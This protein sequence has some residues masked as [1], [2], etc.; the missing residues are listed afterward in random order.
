MAGK[1][2]IYFTLITFIIG[3]M[4]AVQFNTVQKPS[5]RDA[6]DAWELRESINN[7]MELQTKL[8]HE[9]RLQDKKVHDYSSELQ[10]NKEDVLKQTILELKKEAGLTKI[11]GPGIILTVKAIDEGMLLGQPPPQTSPIVLQRLIN[12]LNM[13]GAKSIAIDGERYINTTV[14]RDINGETKVG[15]HAINYLPFQIHVLTE[16]MEIAEKLYNHMQISPVLDDFFI[17]NLQ[18]DVS[19]PKKSIEL[20]A[21]VYPITTRDME[22]VEEKGDV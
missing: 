5:N 9:I 8:L 22:P 17:D 7:E 16:S 19:D 2:K 21:Y 12:E 3:F 18:I 4:V 1:T 14:I 15:D 13:H 11:E 10:D 6:R 20:P